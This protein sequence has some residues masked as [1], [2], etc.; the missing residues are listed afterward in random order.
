MWACLSGARGL[1]VSL[2]VEEDRAAHETPRASCDAR[3]GFK[4][5]SETHRCCSLDPLLALDHLVQ[6]KWITAFLFLGGEE[7]DGRNTTEQVES[8]VHRTRGVRERHGR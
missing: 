4:R 6:E 5:A 7:M 2:T 8:S 1:C 3:R